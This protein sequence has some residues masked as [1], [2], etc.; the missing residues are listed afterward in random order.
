MGNAKLLLA[1]KGSP[2]PNIRR[3]YL[4]SRCPSLRKGTDVLHV[5]GA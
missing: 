5:D 2:S 3:I 4:Y 1:K